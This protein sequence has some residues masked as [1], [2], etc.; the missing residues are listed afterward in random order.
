MLGQRFFT[1]VEGAILH[2]IPFENG[3]CFQNIFD[4][5]RIVHTG[6]LYEQLGFVLVAPGRLN[7]RFRQ[8][9]PIDLPLDGQ[10][11][12]LHGVVTD[13]QRRSGLD[14]HAPIGGTARDGSEVPVLKLFRDEPA[15]VARAGG[16]ERP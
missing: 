4:T 11:R 10:H 7:R 5:G 16:R 13:L 6:Q 8:A 2:L 14:G 15:E 9:Q 1:G 12:L 3:L